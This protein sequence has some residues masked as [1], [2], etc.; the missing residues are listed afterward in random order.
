MVLEK[1]NYSLG[2]THTKDQAGL[3]QLAKTGRYGKNCG[4]SLCLTKTSQILI[5]L[6]TY[7]KTAFIIAITQGQ[8]VTTTITFQNSVHQN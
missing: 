3:F 4:Y 1:E 7:S 8:K 2:R 6:V 5:L